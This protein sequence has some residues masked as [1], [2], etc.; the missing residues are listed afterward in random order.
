MSSTFDDRVDGVTASISFKAP[1]IA[2]TRSN[3][4][5]NDEQTIDTVAIVD[6]DRVLV[7]DQTD[8]T[9]NGIYVCKI[10]AGRNTATI[11]I[12]VAK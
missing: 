11:K 4:T 3:I 7:K 10:Q 9:E 1:C 12:A 5:L 2:A 8:D 6:G